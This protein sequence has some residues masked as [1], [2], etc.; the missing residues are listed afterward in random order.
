[1]FKVERYGETPAPIKPPPPPPAAFIPPPQR[2]PPMQRFPP[3]GGKPGFETREE[4]VDWRE[5]KQRKKRWALDIERELDEK[6]GESSAATHGEPADDDAQHKA[7]RQ[8]VDPKDKKRSRG[9]SK[10]KE[11]KLKKA[12]DSNANLMPLGEKSDGVSTK[13]AEAPVVEDPIAEVEGAEMESAEVEVA[14]EHVEEAMDDVEAVGDGP[15]A[16][17]E[18]TPMETLPEESEPL[19]DAEPEEDPNAYLFAKIPSTIK[20]SNLKSQGL[21][22]WL[23]NP[24]RISATLTTKTFESSTANPAFNLSKHTQARLATMGIEYLFPVQQAVLPKLLLSRYSSSPRTPPGDLL[25]S[26]ATGSG[27]TLAYVLPILEYLMSNPIAATFTTARVIPRLRALIVVPTRDL[28]VQVKTT[29]EQL[30]KGSTIRIGVVTGSMSFTAEQEMLVEAGG[31][32]DV[33]TE[34]LADGQCCKVDVLVATP[35]RLTDHLKGTPG[36]SLR[37]LRFLVLDEADRLLVQDYQGWLSMVLKGVKEDLISSDGVALIDDDGG[38]ATHSKSRYDRYLSVGCCRPNE[39]STHADSPVGQEWKSLGFK[40]DELGMPLH[41]VVSLR[42]EQVQQ[43]DEGN[44]RNKFG[45]YTIRHHTPLQKLL[46]S[47]TLTRNPEKIA[48]LHLTNPSYIAVSTATSTPAT[49]AIDGQDVPAGDQEPIEEEE[50]DLSIER[51]NAPPTLTEHMIVVD[52]TSAKP[53]ALLHL[54]FNLKLSGLL[55]FTRSVESAHRL[56]TL[57]ESVS[58]L[59]HAASASSPVV[60]ARAISSDLSTADR[61]RLVAKFSQGN[62][63]ALVCSD[64]MARG[65]DLG[66]SVKGVVNYDVP[67][68]SGGVKTYVHRVGRT[69]RAGREGDAWSIVEE[70]EARWF[71]KEV[72][73]MVTRSDGKT[74]GRVRVGEQEVQGELKNAYGKALGQL[75]LLVNK[76]K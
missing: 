2:P 60:T 48:S 50:E 18:N 11:R 1:M 8:R 47:A 63:C 65:M 56:A 32:R 31:G 24:T 17:A 38:L 19:Q 52:A 70:K 15:D 36:F 9:G 39:D 30:S 73:G 16:D 61:K 33:G 27:K 75:A 46:F 64:V 69:A 23:S 41:N 21:P 26:S 13:N 51:Y 40:V 54:L 74:V 37:H 22:N 20:K 45:G 6:R 35:G 10:N 76:R 59:L 42:H 71:K 72:L 7:K 25:V 55:I 57:I 34:G 14:E 29:L 4:K 67:S 66:E 68:S 49:V 3:G 62:L 43:L 12:A 28:A 58:T 5:V 53:L 44:V